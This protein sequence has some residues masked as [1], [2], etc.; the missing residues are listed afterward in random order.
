[1]T[2]LYR[3]EIPVTGGNSYR[4]CDDDF[5]THA[6]GPCR[7]VQWHFNCSLFCFVYPNSLIKRNRYPLQP[8]RMSAI[9]VSNPN[10]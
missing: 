5:R 3:W 7:S 9:G 10:R 2:E 4:A 6:F 8:D 1:M